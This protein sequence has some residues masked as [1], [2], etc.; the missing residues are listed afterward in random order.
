MGLFQAGIGFLGGWGGASL[1]SMSLHFLPLLLA[2][3]TF[4]VASSSWLKLKVLVSPWKNDCD[5]RSLF[6]SIGQE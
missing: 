5:Q 4:I 2:P 3:L 1:N 6:P